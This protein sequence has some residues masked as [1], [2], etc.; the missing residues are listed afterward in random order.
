MNQ[1][2]LISNRAMAIPLLTLLIFVSLAGAVLVAL[3]IMW[4]G[5][6]S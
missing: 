5:D 1:L 3:R 2:K 6:F 4:T